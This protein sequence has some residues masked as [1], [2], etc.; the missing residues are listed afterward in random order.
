M[1]LCPPRLLRWEKG[2]AE[3]ERRS[4]GEITIGRELCWRLVWRRE[5]GSVEEAGWNLW[6]ARAKVT[7]GAS[8]SDKSTEEFGRNFAGS[9]VIKVTK[10]KKKCVFVCVCLWFWS[11][12]SFLL[13]LKFPSS[14]E[15]SLSY[16]CPVFPLLFFFWSLSSL[17]CVGLLY[18]FFALSVFGTQHY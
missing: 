1:A 2:W 14:C 4:R 12:V 10:Y 8:G 7:Q 15:T 3:N 11:L 5:M 17:I 16:S 13:R 18:V 9:L 6:T